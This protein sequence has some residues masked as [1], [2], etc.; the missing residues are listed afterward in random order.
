[1]KKIFAAALTVLL[2]LCNSVFAQDLDLKDKAKVEL[3]KQKLFAGKTKAALAVFKEL[4]TSNPNNGNVQYYVALCYYN[5]RE[6]SSAFDH[7]SKAKAAPETNKETFYYLGQLNLKD[8]KFD[9]ALADFNTFKSKV[10]EKEGNSEYDIDLAI[11]YCNNAKEYS[12]KPVDVKIENMGT[13]INSQYDD[14]TPCITADGKKLVFNSRRPETTDAP[15][16]VEGDGRY[17]EDIYM[18]Q[19]DTLNHKWTPAEPVPGN[20]NTDAHDGVLSISPDGKQIFIYLNDPNGESRG[21][22]IY[23]SKVAG[24]KWKTPE[25]LNKPI[26]TTYWE[27]G[28]CISPDGKTMFFVSE[29]PKYGKEKGFG[30]ADIWMV[31]KISKTE[32]GKPKNLGPEVNSPYQEV[33][34]FLAPDGKTLFFCSNNKQSMGDYDIFK[35]TLTAGKWSKPVN[36]GFPI[37]S[38]RRDGPFVLSADPKTAYF[39]SDRKGGL[40]ETDIYTIDLSNY[41]VLESDMKKKTN[42]GLSILKGAVRDG[43][44]GTG[45]EGIEVKITDEAGATVATTNTDQNGE[46]FITL[47][48][49]SK[50]KIQIEKKGF[51]KIDE[52]IDLPLGKGGETFS[53]EKQFLLNKEK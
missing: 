13:V 25:S 53:L 44:Q 31:E 16:D 33:G 30:Q 6:Y 19:W 14:K 45:I 47:K 37:N 18:S 9:E 2:L 24:N 32:W 20:V 4:L 11:S 48:G 49:D 26:N 28:A 8:G 3:A 29:S 52:A 41:S 36:L 51:V 5:L 46:Y 39:S 17:F 23:V 12:K 27:G 15:L 34:I 1:M 7:F 50:Y 10:S 42:N 38:E 43:F 21:G 22:D 35:T 40:G